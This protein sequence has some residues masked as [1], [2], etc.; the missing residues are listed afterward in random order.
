MKNYILSL[1]LIFLC[2]S[3]SGVS[4]ITPQRKVADNVD[5]S[6]LYKQ[7]FLQKINSIKAKTR[8]GKNDA[9]L[10]DLGAI[11][12]DNLS[13]PERATRKNLIGVIN[14]STKRYELA[15]KNFEEASGLSK[16]DPSL[17]AQI[18]LNLGSAYYKMNQNEKALATLSLANYKNLLDNE[19]KKYHQLYALLSQQLGKKEQSLSALIRSLE[20]K[21]NINDLKAESRYSQVEEQ[22]LKLST[23]ERVR[24]L[25]EFDQEKNIVVPYLAYKEAE[26]AFREGDQNKVNDF[27]E[28]IEKRYGNNVEIMALVKTLT[29][30]NQNN[31]TK[32]DI[33]YVGVALPLSGEA[34]GL[35]E[36]VLAGIDIALEDLS[37]DP[38]KKYRMEIKDTKGNAANG[39][40]AV[41]ELIETNNVAAIIGGLNSA[42]ATKEYLET[43]K[44]GVMFISLSKVLLPK[45][46]KS[47]LLIE[48]PGSIESQV[49]YLFSDKMTAKMGRRPAIMYPKTDIG[50]A[51]ANEFWR[52]SKKL[53]LD[54]TGLISFD[55]TQTDFRDPVKNILGIKFNREREEELAVVNDIA[56]LESKKSIKRLQNLQPQID[57]DWIFVPALPREVVQLLPNFNYFDAFNLNYIGVPSWR[58]E[59]MLNEGYRYGNVYFMD[60]ALNSAQTPFTQKF[61]AKFKK[62]PN[63]VETIAYDSLKIFSEVVEAGGSFDTRQDLDVALTKKAS[64]QSESGLFKLQDDVWLKDM[65]TYKIKREG[66]EA[67]FN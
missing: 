57:F 15:S 44:Y 6:K 19:A 37:M 42:E 66:I 65:S 64:L 25:E 63:I 34:K 1:G 16:E 26:V 14:F 22:F 31:S 40:F 48:I 45:E 62:Q 21:K 43:K 20:D 56:S 41:K 12:E 18:Y 55:P 39:A 36:R 61:F 29:I 2:T 38:T 17:E 8:Q 33:R 46:E 9:A 58:S 50:E 27:S 52:Q 23:S 60:E 24:L 47:H 35:G 28:W 5:T 32:I 67:A 10:K 3:C 13:S 51:Y 11:K 49:N 4:M 54:V 59:L 53:N 30:R 7:D